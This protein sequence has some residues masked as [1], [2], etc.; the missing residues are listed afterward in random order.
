MDSL[1]KEKEKI[2]RGILSLKTRR[3]DWNTNAKIVIEKCFKETVEKSRNIKFPF[4]LHC[5]V[6]TSNINEET[7][8]LMAGINSTGVFLNEVKHHENT[9]EKVTTHVLEKGCALVA[10][11]SIDGTVSFIISPY[12]SERHSM[13][14]EN[15]FIRYGMPPKKITEQDLTKIISTFLFYSRFTSIFGIRNSFNI[16]DLLHYYYLLFLDIRNR[17]KI[18]ST[19]MNIANEW[20]KILLGGVVGYIVAMLTK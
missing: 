3:Q 9:V 20:S 11:F 8:Q 7:I 2:E 15:I 16:I 14:E 18:I 1:E 12:K 6:P 13:K 5:V 19:T 17:Q 10:S 4:S